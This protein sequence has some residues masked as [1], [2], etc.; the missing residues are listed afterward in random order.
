METIKHLIPDGGEDGFLKNISELVEE[1]RKKNIE[2]FCLTYKRKEDGSIRT[3]FINRDDPHMLSVLIRLMLDMANAYSE[4]A[5][6]IEE[7]P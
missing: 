6:S 5:Y 4:A 2:C 3:Y 7:Y 1:Y